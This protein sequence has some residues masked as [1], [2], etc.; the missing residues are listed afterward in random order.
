MN[1][2]KYS[3]TNFLEHCYEF[4][5]KSCSLIPDKERLN[6]DTPYTI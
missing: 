3:P 1:L 4:S 2:V 6:E 5:I